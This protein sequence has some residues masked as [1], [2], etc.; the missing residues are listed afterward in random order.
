M[1][2]KNGDTNQ[3]TC[4]G[5]NNMYAQT[6]PKTGIQ[7]QY[8]KSRD[9]LSRFAF[10]FEGYFNCG[11]CDHRNSRDCALANP[12]NFDEQISFAEMWAYKPHTKRPHYKP[13]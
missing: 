5:T 12:E 9:F 7:H 11:L 6:H 2:G 8:D 13:F 1:A 3:F 10:R 4:P